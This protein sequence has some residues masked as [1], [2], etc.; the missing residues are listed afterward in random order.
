MVVVLHLLT[1][2]ILSICTQMAPMKP[3][4]QG[5][6]RHKVRQ[7]LLPEACRIVVAKQKDSQRAFQRAI[8]DAALGIQQTA[9]EIAI[10]HHKSVAAVQA[11]L[12]TTTARKRRTK[13]NGWNAYL[14]AMRQKGER[15]DTLK[16]SVCTDSH[17]LSTGKQATRED[18]L[19]GELSHGL[20]KTYKDIPQDELEDIKKTF[21]TFK[22]ERL[23]GE[24]PT[25]R[26]RLND[27]TQS[28]R[29][30]EAEVR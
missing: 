5:H 15:T 1:K 6:V 9:Q 24:R 12:Y 7:K 17:V 26:S 21:M 23:A 13:V 16:L 25:A 14:W 27:V 22:G 30:F 11:H 4:K 28:V 3:L 2:K 29:R 19:N 18:L 8:R 10:M 20:A